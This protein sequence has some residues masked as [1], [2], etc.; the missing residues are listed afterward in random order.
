MHLLHRTFPI[1]G[2]KK[3]N[4]PRSTGFTLVEI[5]I[6]V[7][8]IGILL[9]IAVPSFITAR[10]ASRAKA[11]VGNL[12]QINSAKT[13]C[14]MDNKIANTATPTFSIDGVTPTAPGPNGTY[15]LVG[16]GGGV[17]YIRLHADLS[18]GRGLHARYGTYAPYL[19][20]R[21]HLGL[22]GLSVRRQMV[23]RILIATA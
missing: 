16:G 13:Q 23:S 14:I 15:Q 7:L 9:A 4:T 5:M 10:E 20:Y 11:C 19:Q 8:I 12:A 3:R 6:V 1:T 17:T 22:N 2:R 21:Y 18:V